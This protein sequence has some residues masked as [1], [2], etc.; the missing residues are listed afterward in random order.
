MRS[1]IK[2]P[3]SRPKIT[4]FDANAVA[5]AVKSTFIGGGPLISRLENKIA[6]Y[7]GR[8]YGVCVANGTQALYIALK[9][10][11]LPKGS[12]ILVPSFTIISALFAIYQCGYDPVFVD[13]NE[14]TWNV[15]IR[16]VE[17]ALSQHVDAA[18]LVETYASSPPMSHIVN[19]LKKHNI[20]VIEDS[21][22]G[23]GGSYNGKKF[24]SFGDVSILSLYVNKLITTGEGGVV[25]TD[26][27]SLYTKICLL[28]NLFF[29]KERS[30]IH[31]ELSGNSRITNYQAALGLS[32]FKRIDKFYN[33]RKYLYERYLDL[34]KEY[35]EYIKFQ[36]IP[37]NIESSYWVFPILLQ[38][39][40]GYTATQFLSELNKKNIEARHFFYPLDKQPFLSSDKGIN[41]SVSYH[42]WLYGLYIPMGNGIHEEEV[43]KT[44]QEVKNILL[45]REKEG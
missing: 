37:Y 32:Q 3:V 23:F 30:F 1:S 28:R 34:L 11:D 41:S 20:P 2:I 29:D 38:K 44:V 27:D 40:S 5:K 17:L 25:L 39:K 7:C 6:H 22:E 18:L 24:G 4:N 9:S 13:V 43:I 21:A 12:K 26:S 8:K 45:K 16:K 14:K 31:R 15:D 19:M 36:Y 35:K 10:L 33:Y 42:L